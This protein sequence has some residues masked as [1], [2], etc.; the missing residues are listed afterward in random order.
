MSHR[1]EDDAASH[2]HHEHD[3][4]AAALASLGYQSEFKRDMSLW[5]N[6]ALGF[7]YLSPVVGIYTLFAV[8]LITGGPAMIWWLVIVG[9]GQLLVALVFGEIVSQYPVAGGVYPWAR[10]LWGR[11]WAWMTGWVYLVALLTTIAGVVY[12]SGPFLA[13]LVGFTPGEASTITCALI[14]LAVALAINLMGTRWLAT[15][16]IIGF[17]AELLGAIA[18]GAWLLLTERHHNLSVLFD[19]EGVVGHSGGYLSAFLAAALIGIYQYYGFEA[20]GDVAEEVP[21]PA[22]QIPKAMRMTI[23]VGGAAAIFVCLSLLLAVADYAAVIDGTDADPVTTVLHNAF[24]EGGTK[25]VLVVVMLSFLSCAL[26]LMAA[27]SRLMYSYARDD[28]IFGSR[29]FRTFLPH[30]HVPPY[31]MVVAAIVPAVIVLGSVFSTKALTSIISFATLGI[32]LGFH[33]VT[34]AAL[35]ARLKGWVPSGAFTLGRWGMLVN[36]AALAYGVLAMVNMAWPRTPDLPWYDNWLVALSAAIGAAVGLA[37]MLLVR[38]YER[39]NAPAGDAIPRR[40]GPPGPAETAAPTR[41]RG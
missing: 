8:G 31:A 11:K 16:A 23:Y 2:Q 5:A 33:M 24:G 21:N 36:V 39:S 10:R 27:A 15:A 29:L 6:F 32:Y 28:M 35:R 40:P 41:S 9:V 38:P 3:A 14:L 20:C 13:Q 26:S 19:T 25:V 1:L 30:R 37:Y 34:A 7:T 18:V 4:D 17:S 12:G 22:R